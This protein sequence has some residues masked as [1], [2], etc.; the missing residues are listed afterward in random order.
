MGLGDPGGL[1]LG[2][3]VAVRRGW[4]TA[5]KG[6]QVSPPTEDEFEAAVARAG[7]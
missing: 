2:Q 3:W 1:S 5:H 6:R 7:S 4:E